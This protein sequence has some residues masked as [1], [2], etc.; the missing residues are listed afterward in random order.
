MENARLIRDMIAFYHSRTHDVEHFLKVFAY[1]QTIGKLTGLD[2]QTKRILEIAAITHDIA[3][4]CAGKS[5]AAPMVLCR[6]RKAS[7]SCGISSRRTTCL[8][9]F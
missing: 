1:A 4:P 2:A 9:P 5:M 3:C 8:S 7:P 6:S